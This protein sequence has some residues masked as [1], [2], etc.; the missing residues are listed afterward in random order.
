MSEP[1]KVREMLMGIAAYVDA[2]VTENDELRRQLGIAP[3][4]RIEDL[5]DTRTGH[6]PTSPSGGVA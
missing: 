1:S 4:V 3:G 6:I 5:T 2:V